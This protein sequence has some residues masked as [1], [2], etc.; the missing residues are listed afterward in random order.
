MRRKNE[1]KKIKDKRVY[2]GNKPKKSSKIK[3]REKDIGEKIYERK[4][5]KA[6]QIGD[7]T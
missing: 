7:H 2:I 6:P 4:L 1:R 5:K 3:N